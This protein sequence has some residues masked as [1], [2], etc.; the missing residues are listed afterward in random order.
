MNIQTE[1]IYY[2]VLKHLLKEAEILPT[3]VS[4]SLMTVPDNNITNGIK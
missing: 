2:I 3:S 4:M 1:N